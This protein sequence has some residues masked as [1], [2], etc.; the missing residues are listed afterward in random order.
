MSTQAFIKPKAKKARK[1][2]E[3]PVIRQLFIDDEGLNK[4]ILSSTSKRKTIFLKL[5]GDSK[6]RR[7][8]TVTLSTKTLEIRRSRDKHLF[9]KRNAYGFNEYVLR[10]GKSFNMVWLRDEHQHWKIPVQ[11]ILEKGWYLHF[12]QEGYE[13]QKFMSLTELEKYRVLKKENRRL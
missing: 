10:E 12:K 1:K 13:L 4:I 11:D 8:G 7:I 5:K 6:N 3:K 9:R 2:A